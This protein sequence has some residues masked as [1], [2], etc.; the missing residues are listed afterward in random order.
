MTRAAASLI[1]LSPSITLTI[2]RGAPTR[3]IRAVAAT[4]S[5]GDTIAPSAK[6]IGHDMSITSWATTATAAA[7][8]IT[9]PIDVTEIARMSRRSALRSEKNAAEYS[10]GGR[11]I[12][13]T[14]SGSSSTVGTPGTSASA[15]PPSTSTIGYGT[16]SQLA[17]AL[18]SETETKS[19]TRKTSR[20]SIAA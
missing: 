20:F 14:R 18:S 10:N 13:S 1:R 2:R 4:G 19:A 7:V 3:R 8:T 11:K 15:S 6:D 16:L 17:I 5:V 9:R 12:V